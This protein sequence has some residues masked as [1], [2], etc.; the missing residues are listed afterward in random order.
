MGMEHP[1]PK[2]CPAVAGPHV[3]CLIVAQRPNQPARQRQQWC[4]IKD[5]VINSY[6]VA[7]QHTRQYFS[8]QR[9]SVGAIQMTIVVLLHVG[10]HLCSLVINGGEPCLFAQSETVHFNR[11]DSETVFQQAYKWQKYLVGYAQSGNEQ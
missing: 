5:G 8:T 2:L 1:S 11:D 7:L 3:E 4:R 9:Q 6:L 10:N